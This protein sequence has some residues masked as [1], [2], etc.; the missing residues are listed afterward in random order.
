[1]DE[2]SDCPLSSIQ[3]MKFASAL[4]LAG[5]GGVGWDQQPGKAG[6]G[7]RLRATSIGDGDAI[8]GRH[9]L[10]SG[11]S[12]SGDAIGGG[13]DVLAG[14]VLDR[15]VRPVIAAGVDQFDIAEGAGE[16]GEPFRRRLRCPSGRYRRAT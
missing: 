4:P 9:V 1:M 10:S 5:V 15:A 16:S 3:V 12:G 13:L 8:V 6:D 7:I 14:R 11:G 2:A